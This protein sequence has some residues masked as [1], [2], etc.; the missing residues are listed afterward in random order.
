MPG[1][2]WQHCQARGLEGYQP[3]GSAVGASPVAL[4]PAAIDAVAQAAA[5][6]VG[7]VA[8]QPAAVGAV[9]QAAA[10]A[11]AQAIGPVALQPAAV[12]AVA[13]AAAQAV[14][15]VALQ[16]AAVGAVAQAAAQAVGPVVR[17][18]GAAQAPVGRMPTGWS[19]VPGP[20]G[21]PP[22]VSAA[23]WR[24]RI[25]PMRQR[26]R[27]TAGGA[28]V[29]AVPLSGKEGAGFAR[30]V[31]AV[32]GGTRDGGAEASLAVR[33][34]TSRYFLEHVRARCGP[35]EDARALVQAATGTGPRSATCVS[36]ALLARVFREGGAPVGDRAAWEG[37]A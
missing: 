32:G 34:W 28:Q 13:Q 17:Q 15:P 12:D 14:G 35:G 29:W 1:H 9:A 4:Q 6:A 31:G 36:L 10:Q 25:L 27:L 16:P 33:K 7:P 37:P 2:G 22:Q 23:L 18:A 20:G 21:T 8:L 3:V 26:V 11:V 5:Q 19:K 30:T 24:A